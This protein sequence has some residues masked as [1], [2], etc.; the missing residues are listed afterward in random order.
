[1][2]EDKGGIVKNIST[3]KFTKFYQFIEIPIAIIERI[4][5]R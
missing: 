3:Y 5:N 1:M 2:G 4:G